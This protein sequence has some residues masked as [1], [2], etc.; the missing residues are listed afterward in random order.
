MEAVSWD[1]N[2][3]DETPEPVYGSCVACGAV[4]RHQPV[5][6]LTSPYAT[7][8][9]IRFVRCGACSSLIA[10]AGRFI[11]YTDGLDP[12][13]WRHYLHIG[14]G[15]DFMVRPIERICADGTAPSLLDVGC[16]FGFTLDY[17]RRMTGA[18]VEGVEPSEY[19]RM[20]RDMLGVP[21]HIADLS[22]VP[23]LR[24]RR[25]EIVFSSEVIEHVR[26]PAAFIR[27]LRS[28]LTPGGLW[29]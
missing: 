2:W 24:E 28:H 11:E 23:A 15:I 9:I 26:D 22:D 18:E 20:G 7:G 25:F 29:F 12:A 21:I 19:G 16:G 10:A 27:E 17:W 6:S 14:A 1:I 3:C 8:D 5:L 13:V 4:G